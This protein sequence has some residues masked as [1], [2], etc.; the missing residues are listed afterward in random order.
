[1]CELLAE[2]LPK[3]SVHFQC[4]FLSL[5]LKAKLALVKQGHLAQSLHTTDKGRGGF[6]GQMPRL[7][8][9]GAAAAHT[10]HRLGGGLTD[11][12]KV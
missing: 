9:A 6:K 1:M 8:S 4:E 2:K 11:V 12:F 5:L 3:P 10:A 7:R